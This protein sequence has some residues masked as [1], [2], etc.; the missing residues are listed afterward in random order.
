MTGKT[1]I[2]MR[3]RNEL[4]CQGAAELVTYTE[5]LVVMSTVSGRIAISGTGLRL[6]YMS[7][8]RIVISG[9]IEGFKYE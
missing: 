7:D 8:D 3:G 9:E 5:T 4:F 6:C 1:Y 2:E